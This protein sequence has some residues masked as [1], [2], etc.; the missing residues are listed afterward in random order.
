MKKS[1]K[2]VNVSNIN[3]IPSTGTPGEKLSFSRSSNTTLY[4]LTGDGVVDN[5]AA[6]SLRTFIGG[7]YTGFGLFE[8]KKTNLFRNSS[9][10]GVSTGSPG[11]IG[12]LLNEQIAGNTGGITRTVIAQGT[13]ASGLPYI[14]VRYAGTITDNPV[15]YGMLREDITSGISVGKTITGSCWL[16]LV[17]GSM[18]NVNLD[19]QIFEFNSGSYLTLGY[20]DITLTSTLTRYVHTRTLTDANVN[21][22]RYN[23]QAICNLGEVV[24]FTIRIA[25]PQI[26]ISKT[27]SNP[28]LT[29]SAA[30]TTQGDSLYRPVELADYKKGTILLDWYNDKPTVSGSYKR[31]LFS[32]NDANENRLTCY[33]NNDSSDQVV[34]ICGSATNSISISPVSGFNRMGFSWGSAQGVN[35]ALN[36]VTVSSRAFTSTPGGSSVESIGP[37]IL[38][39]PVVQ[40]RSVFSNKTSPASAAYTVPL[41]SLTSVSASNVLMLANIQWVADNA[42]ETVSGSRYQVS[43]VSYGGEA[44]TQFYNSAVV[45]SLNAPETAV[46]YLKNPVLASGK[47][48]NIGWRG[49]NFARA[50]EVIVLSNV[51]LDNPLVSGMHFASDASDGIT[52]LSAESTTGSLSVAG[53]SFRGYDGFP[54]SV[55]GEWSIQSGV[56]SSASLTTDMAYAFAVKPASKYEEYDNTWT[57]ADRTA[58]YLYFVNGATNV[59]GNDPLLIRSY[60]RYVGETSAN[61]LLSLTDPTSIP[62]F[63]A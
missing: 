25:A 3:I 22:I 23:L 41:T 53:V 6:N 20:T 40:S 17:S 36:G 29:T 16:K 46:F 38:T 50:V 19:L 48:L 14:D 58:G 60:T 27:V 2:T 12:D 55:S 43:A 56:T 11:D 47:S 34:F 30:V 54:V 1:L 8:T 52:T 28:I 13:D 37:A 31:H 42:S 39:T 62:G 21:Q 45:S 44:L 18:S 61:A 9:F 51:N 10:T 15:Y 24:D 4:D 57:V 49:I 33:R 59:L 26:E 7:P 35:V 5:V 63:L 32:I